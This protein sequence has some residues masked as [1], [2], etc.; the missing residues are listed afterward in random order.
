[1]KRGKACTKDMPFGQIVV[2]P[3]GSYFIHSQK[4]KR[5]WR[6]GLG[7]GIGSLLATSSE[8]DCCKMR[9]FFLVCSALSWVRF[10]T[11]VD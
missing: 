4:K 10:R 6:L 9:T 3:A 11:G 2:G 1:M 5:C 7:I 8:N